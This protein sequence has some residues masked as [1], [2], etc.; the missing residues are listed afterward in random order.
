MGQTVKESQAQKERMD[1]EGYCWLLL[2]F[3]C[4]L[5]LTIY[6][7]FIMQI[8][9]F[10]FPWSL[11]AIHTLCSGIGCYVSVYG[12]RAFQPAKLS[13]N[14][15]IVM[16]AFSVLYTINIAVSNI[17]L[18]MVS[19]PFHQ[20]VRATT[21]VFTI[22]M[23]VLFLQKSY[24]TMM[25]VSLVPVIVGVALATLGDYNYSFMGFFLTLLGT[26]LAAVK[27]IV[28]NVVQVG[29]LKL[30]PLDLLLRMSPLAFI[31]CVVIASFSG[32][33]DQVLNYY[34][35]KFD[36]KVFFILLLNGVIAFALNVVSFTANKKTSALTMTVAANVKQ[37]SL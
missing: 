36:S 2:Y 29:K 34:N 17:S 11:T 32:E 21:P 12:F 14:E 24:S 30:H 10:S 27:T 28:T 31:Q 4:N 35:T 22:I 23:N 13:D 16:I 15:N 18:N 3:F 19:V 7:K 26:F 20:V 8:T 25:Y 1:V 37:V 9:G 5:T 6:N 33:G